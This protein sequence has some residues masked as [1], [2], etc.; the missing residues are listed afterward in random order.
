MGAGAS[1][2]SIYVSKRPEYEALI[3]YFYMFGAD[4]VNNW[5]VTL[6]SYLKSQDFSIMII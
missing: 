1:T 2:T 6:E 3:Q 4:M 5:T